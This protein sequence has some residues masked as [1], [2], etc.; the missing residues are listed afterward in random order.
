MA[1]QNPQPED[2]NERK[3]QKPFRK[4][5]LRGLAVVLPPLLTIVIFLWVWNT[6]RQYVLIPVENGARHVIT[7][8]IE[9]V[10][11]SVPAERENPDANEL[12][13]VQSFAYKGIVFQRIESGE[14][15]PLHV[16]EEV[17]QDRPRRDVSTG[18][19]YYDAYVEIHYLKWYYVIPV[20]LALFVGLMYLL[21]KFLAAGIGRFVWILFERAIS[22]VPV[23]RPVYSSVKQ[24]TDFVFSEREIEYTRV[25]AVE[26]PRRGMWSL[27]FVTG[28]SMVDIRT[29]ANEPVV[30]CL[31][32]TS[33]MPATGFTITVPKSETIDLNITIDQ[34]FQFCVSCG[35]VIPKNQLQ[36]PEEVAGMIN[37]TVALQDQR[38]SGES[39]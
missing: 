30:S 11:D 4:A 26:Y 37:S 32:P 34:A 15:I 2:T 25:V 13:V 18:A 22:R 20:F 9:D 23:V 3:A 36:T 28:E 1:E 35:V 38:T 29:A 12:G 10:Q 8:F 21:G 5:V 24:V 19:E 6:V 39:E 31:I 33:P 7:Y 14:Y 17:R 16:Y 27:G